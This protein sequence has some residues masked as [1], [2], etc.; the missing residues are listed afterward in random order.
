MISFAAIKAIDFE[1]D[2]GK[3]GA[4]MKLVLAASMVALVGGQALAA[5][6]PTPTPLPGVKYFPTAAYNWG[7]GYF[8]LNGGYG[9]GQSEWTLAGVSTGSF[10]VNGFLFGG[11]LGANF[12]T[13]RLV[14]GLEGDFDWSGITGSS[15]VAACAAIGAPI[16]AACQ[17]K[18]ANWLSTGR[19]R[20]GY[21]FDRILVFATGGLALTNLEVAFTQPAVTVSDVVGGWTVGAGIEFAFADNWTAKAEYLFVDFGKITCTVSLPVCGTGTVSLTENIVRAGINYKF[22]W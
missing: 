4:L 2:P 9:F 20:V 14:L 13:G 21:A 17:T 16:G 11:T 12:Q 5:D 19:G 10:N 6:L 3:L 15:S 1:S 18:S 8:G 7:G 22:Y